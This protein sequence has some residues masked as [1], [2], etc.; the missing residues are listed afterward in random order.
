MTRFVSFKEHIG[1]QGRSLVLAAL[2]LGL[3][4]YP[5]FLGVAYFVNVPWIFYSFWYFVKQFLDADTL[6]KVN[7]TS[8]DYIDVLQ[9]G[10]LGIDIDNIPQMLGGNFS[11]YNESFNFDTSID[12]PLYYPG[13]PISEDLATELQYKDNNAYRDKISDSVESSIQ[14][15]DNGVIDICQSSSECNEIRV[16]NASPK[17]DSDYP[18]NE[19]LTNETLENKV[20]AQDKLFLFFKISLLPIYIIFILIYRLEKIGWV[21]FPLL[22]IILFSDEL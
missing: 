3:P 12:G 17:S 13:A 19:N 2:K 7:M 6:R 11:L 18:K 16:L 5:D 22:V 4:N 20:N 8:D 14:S 15:K 10:D 1:K 9:T 21:V